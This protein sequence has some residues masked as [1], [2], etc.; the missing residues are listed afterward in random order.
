[1]GAGLEIDFIEPYGFFMSGSYHF[2]IGEENGGGNDITF[3]TDD[4]RFFN[5]S[6]GAY[7]KF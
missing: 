5:I 1:M 2:V 4:V 7:M 6:I 3:P